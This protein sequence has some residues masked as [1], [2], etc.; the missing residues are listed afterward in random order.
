MCLQGLRATGLA[1]SPH[2]V[3]EEADS[4]RESGLPGVPQQISSRAALGPR[5]PDSYL[6][7]WGWWGG[8]QME[9]RPSLTTTP[10]HLA[11]A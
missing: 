7:P 10:R 4:D 2:S 6:G 11:T 9:R 1:D 5:A 8:E 3:E